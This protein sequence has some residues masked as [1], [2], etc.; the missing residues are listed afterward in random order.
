MNSRISLKVSTDRFFVFIYFVE[1]LVDLTDSAP[2]E[3]KIWPEITDAVDA[4]PPA[5]EKGKGKGKEAEKKKID[6]SSK[7]YPYLPKI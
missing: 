5:E 7:R 2:P 4:A 3:K 1:V 6:V